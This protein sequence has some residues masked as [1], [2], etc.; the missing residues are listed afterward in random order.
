MAA[1]NNLITNF[2]VTGVNYRKTDASIRS[3]FAVQ[4]EG[5]ARLLH[6]AGRM[7]VSECFLLSTCNRTEIYGIA[8][9]AAS[10]SALLCTETRGSHA[11]FTANAYVKKGR[12]AVQHL[13][14]VASGLDSQIL[15]DYEIVGQIKKAV[16]TAKEHGLVGT[17]M[18]RLTSMA[19]QCSKAVKANTC[20]SGGTVSVS[21]AAV[22]YI[23]DHVPGYADA[24]IAMVGTGKFGRNTCKNLVDY[25]GARDITLL[26]RT[27]EKAVQLAEIFGLQSAPLSELSSVARRAD[28][29][30]VATDAPEPV[31]KRAHVE[32]S[33]PKWVIDLSIPH[34]VEESV[35]H[36]PGITTVNVDELS[37]IKDE[38]LARREADVP[39]A[40]EI[41]RLRVG[42]FAEWLAMR[43]HAPILREMKSKLLEI[44]QSGHT[45]FTRKGLNGGSGPDYQIQRVINDMAARMR[46]NSLQGCH[47]IQAL[48]EFMS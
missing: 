10:L 47:Y 26:N 17:F 9:D 25:L 7:Q 13:F 43:N 15:G 24:R 36:L 31:L 5:Y 32:A 1:S 33:G 20:L 29:I 39:M 46:S 23:R 18:D 40:M 19:F 28:I 16:K 21:F 45:E 48:H 4:D 6:G 12:D 22:Q 37:R 42:E 2:F 27:E 34:N 30:L 14:E 35:R 8:P 41:V 3:K 11:E 38:T 44:H